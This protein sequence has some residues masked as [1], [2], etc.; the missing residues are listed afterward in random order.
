MFS[1]KKKLGFMC[2]QMLDEFQVCWDV[3]LWEGG[4]F[5]VN[6]TQ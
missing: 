4:N 6:H 5:L 3:N 1:E 2:K